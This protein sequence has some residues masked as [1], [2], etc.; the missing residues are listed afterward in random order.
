MVTAGAAG[1]RAANLDC[2]TR[3]HSIGYYWPGVCSHHSDG[4]FDFQNIIQPIE[5]DLMARPWAMSHVLM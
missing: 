5:D 1:H 2:E 3:R 4:V